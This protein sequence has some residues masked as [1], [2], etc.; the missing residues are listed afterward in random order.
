MRKI[1]KK[2]L[3]EVLAR[4]A[5]CERADEGNCDGSLTME[6]AFIY[7]GRQIDEAWSILRICSYHHAVNEYQDGG[8]LDKRK[9]E[10]LALN[11][12][13]S[14]DLAKYPRKDWESLKE[15]LD[16]IYG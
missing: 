2:V 7:A 12:A 10:W 1:S 16:K 6:H 9:H 8:D 14:E 4:P 11:H 15:Q 13:T 5:V 3:E